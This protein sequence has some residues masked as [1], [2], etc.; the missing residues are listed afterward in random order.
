MPK[1]SFHFRFR[2]KADMAGR[3]AG[4]VPVENDQ[5]GRNRARRLKSGDDPDETL[6]NRATAPYLGGATLYLNTKIPGDAKN[7]E[8]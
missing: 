5:S 2:G 4:R 6:G 1:P 7:G 3:A 8:P